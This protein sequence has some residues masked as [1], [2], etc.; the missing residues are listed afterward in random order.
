VLIYDLGG[1]A[2]LYALN[3][4]T[5]AFPSH[6][7]IASLRKEYDLVISVGKIKMLDLFANIETGFK[8][9]PPGHQRTGVSMCMDEVACEDRLVW[10]RKTDEM[11]GVCEHAAE[12]ES[13]LTMGG[14]LTNVQALVRAI[15]EV[16]TVHIGHEVT[17]IAFARHDATNYGAKPVLILPTCKQGDYY[18]AAEQLALVME[19]WRLS[20]YGEKLHGP[21]WSIGSDGD[22]KRRPAFCMNYM[23]RRMLESDSLYK[24]LG[25]VLGLNLYTGKN[26]VTPALD[27]KHDFKREFTFS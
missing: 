11:A 21:V 3:H 5:T 27:W 23:W 20:P 17:V 9:V 24:H 25:N 14:D 16:K 22:P 7:C 4:A 18:G 8:D 19:A 6:Q 15:K 12:L 2:A 26:F 1:D 13:P 10:L